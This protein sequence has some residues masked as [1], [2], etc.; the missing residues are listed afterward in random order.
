MEGVGSYIDQALVGGI[1]SGV[2]LLVAMGWLLFAQNALWR[3]HLRAVSEPCFRALSTEYG[4]VLLP[5]GF[6]AQIGLEGRIYNQDVVIML[7]GGTQGVQVELNVSEDQTTR[8]STVS[9]ASLQSGLLDW[10]F[11]ELNPPEE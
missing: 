1:L 6:R 2:L 8:K 3:V 9:W 7:K 11:H 10:V 4:L 5:V